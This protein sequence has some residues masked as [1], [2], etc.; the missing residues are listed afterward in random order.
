MKLQLQEQ[1]SYSLSAAESEQIIR[2][3]SSR[4]AIYNSRNLTC[5][6]KSNGALVFKVQRRQSF[7]KLPDHSTAASS[8]SS[9]SI[10]SKQATSNTN[11]D[12]VSQANDDHFASDKN[13][14]DDWGDFAG[15]EGQPSS[16]GDST[17]VDQTS[18]FTPAKSV[19]LSEQA[20]RWLQTLPDLRYILSTT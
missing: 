20:E 17:T 13:V 11:H 3:F 14:E 6:Q 19:E 10:T 9:S 4:S 1:Q 12:H 7:N 15:T 8:S 18:T 16:A 5:S 2:V